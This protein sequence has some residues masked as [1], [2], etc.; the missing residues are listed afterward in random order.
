MFLSTKLTVM[1]PHKFVEGYV[2]C[3]KSGK[4][5]AS[6]SATIP[7]PLYRTFDEICQIIEQH[8]I[9]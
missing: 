1:L 6:A 8:D 7:P 4:M 5:G 9:S 2:L 3:K